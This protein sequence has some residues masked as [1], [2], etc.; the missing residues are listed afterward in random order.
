MN[1]EATNRCD[2]NCTV[3]QVWDS[4]V[5]KEILDSIGEPIEISEQSEPIEING[6]E[7]CKRKLN[8]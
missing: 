8:L 7:L 3:Q 4:T 5:E 6:N 2:C 1:T